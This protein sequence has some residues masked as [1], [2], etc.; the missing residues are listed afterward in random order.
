[1][2]TNEKARASKKFLMSNREQTKHR[3]M[4]RIS[5]LAG[6]PAPHAPEYRLNRNLTIAALARRARAQINY[7]NR[8]RA[9]KT[10]LL[11]WR[12][13][14][15]REKMQFGNLLAHEPEEGNEGAYRTILRPVEERD[16]ADAA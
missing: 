6:T 1:M 15:N 4:K 10:S 8:H 3:V 13:E 16:R 9:T 7:R 14:M 5:H 12:M 11:I 2:W